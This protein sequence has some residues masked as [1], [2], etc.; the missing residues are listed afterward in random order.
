MVISL[1]KIAQI[2]RNRKTY[3]RGVSCY[4]AGKVRHFLFQDNALSAQVESK[5]G[6]ETY[7]VSARFGP[8]GSIC[9]YS[10]TCSSFVP[11]S[12]ACKHIAAALIHKYYADMIAGAPKLEP[13]AERTGSDPS[14]KTMIQQYLAAEEQQLRLAAAQ[15]EQ[16]ALLPTL[17]VDERESSLSF[18]VGHKRQYIIKD[19]SQFFCHMTN[20]EEVSYGTQL[21]LVHHPDSFLD[22]SKPLLEFLMSEM[23]D[24]KNR[25]AMRFSS[26]YFPINIGRKLP[27]TP[28]ALDRFFH[29][30]PAGEDHAI[31]C[32]GLP[33]TDT[34]RPVTGHPSLSVNVAWDAE[35]DGLELS[36]DWPVMLWGQEYL[37][38]LSQG[39]VYR[40]DRAFYNPLLPFIT[41]LK[42]GR[43]KL[44][45]ASED[46]GDFCSSVLPVLEQRLTLTGDPQV[47]DRYRPYEPEVA[48]YLDAPSRDSVTA[49][50]EMQYGDTV[51]YPYAVQQTKPDCGL[52]RNTSA[53]LRV[54]L[55]VEQWFTPGGAPAEGTAQPDDVLV[56]RDTS[57]D[58]L[59]R[60]MTEGVAALSAVGTLYVSDQFQNSGTA[61]PPKMSVGVSLS[62]DLLDISIDTGWLDTE[63]LVELLRSYRS[64]KRYHRLRSGQFLSLEDETIRLLS[65]MVDGLA[66]TDKQLKKGKITVPKYRALY[67]DQLLQE[68]HQLPFWRNTAFRS[69]VKAIK[70][71][72]DSEFL[73]PKS[74]CSVLRT[75]QK[76][77]FRWLKTMD[78]Y[79]FG[80]ILADDMGLGKTLQ[81][82][83]LLLDAKESGNQTPSLVVCPTSL[84]YNWQSEIER[85]APSLK[86]LPLV[87]DAAERAE[88]IRRIGEYDVVVTS[89][90]LLRRDV[91]QYQGME[92]RFHILDEAQYIKNHTTQNAKAVKLIQS[93]Q[94][95]ALTGTPIENRL[96]ELWSIFDFL[97]PG[98]L[99]SH[100][101]FREQ[102]ELPIVKYGDEEALEK[103]RRMCSPF[104]LR[105]LKKD[106]LLELP[107]K[108]ETVLYVAMEE[109]QKKL[110]LANALQIK[111]DLVRNME[112][113]GFENA[114]MQVL[115][116][117]TRLRQ[118]CCH[119]SLCYDNYTG[120]SAKLESC[121]ELVRNA[122]NAG[123]KVL[124]FSQFT[125]MLDIIQTRLEAEHITCYR[126]QG[127]TPKEKRSALVENFN[128]QDSPVSV[129]LISLKAGG[130]G[131]NLTGADV[132]IHYDPW[133]NLAAQNQATDRAHRIGQRNNVQVYKLIV[134][135]TI[136]EKILQLQQAK[137]QLADAVIREGD[138]LASMTKE[139]ILQIL[140]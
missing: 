67:L 13:V 130:T 57:E 27:L 127:S 101:R 121:V 21:T 35:R 9:H 31:A 118:L 136:E 19:L 103:L 70:T 117:L 64:R 94:R 138:G 12:G 55:A 95:F 134:K 54:R 48:I 53:E 131:L 46:V 102:Y 17:H 73:P 63:E 129:F 86:V 137:H 62:V 15:T 123:H 68:S 28:A 74:L 10:C 133:W 135:D 139:E 79:G 41:A 97:M 6:R 82:I 44:F 3:L 52:I 42:D 7:F 80:G 92:F 110:Y 45:L 37:Y 39:K 83:S 93:R 58:G 99:Y 1:R 88:K 125:S 5:D 56:L 91:E 78:Y 90:E 49:R 72:S 51:V 98:F 61:P 104:I 81:M 108:T 50:V 43:G 140:G 34:L 126:L 32:T 100:S 11:Y 22:S 85:F 65:R 109:D 132:V 20:Q 26:N 25:S 69:L 33:D 107:D 122:T 114:K 66:L 59:F 4:N 89:Y 40:L 115:A 124:L 84:I 120:E 16:V 87:G 38:V 112:R 113:Y 106:V 36:A 47:L 105:R 75:Y 24:I 119:P 111:Q 30:Y 76:T 2:A 14:A 18:T 23:S 96:S 71:V 29:L 60:F 8:G 77:G 116:A 128:R